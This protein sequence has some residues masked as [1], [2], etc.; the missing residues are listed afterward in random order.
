MSS[1][2]AE[3]PTITIREKT[4]QLR[5]YSVGFETKVLPVVRGLLEDPSDRNL[6]VMAIVAFAVFHSLPAAEAHALLIDNKAAET[7]LD[8]AQMELSAA[9]FEAVADY[10]EGVNK[11]TEAAAVTVDSSPGKP[12]TGETP[13]P[14]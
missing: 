3:P 13:P 7:A 12:P 9:D 1:F 6:G 11:R 10:I 2:T 5:P 14:T 4:A 8:V